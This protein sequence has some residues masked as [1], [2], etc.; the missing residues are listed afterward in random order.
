M[1][2]E[3]F[4]P[5]LSSADHDVNVR[6]NKRHTAAASPSSA[7][8]V[9]V[10]ITKRE[11]DFLQQ[12]P[13]TA[14][15]ATQD[16]AVKPERDQVQPALQLHPS[17]VPVSRSPGTAAQ[18]IH[19]VG[20]IGSSH[21]GDQDSTARAPMQTTPRAAMAAAAGDIKAVVLLLGSSNEQQQKD[22]ARQLA[23]MTLHG[24]GSHR[25]TIAAEA[26]VLVIAAAGV[27]VILRTPHRGSR[28]FQQ[29]QQPLHGMLYLVITLNLLCATAWLGCISPIS[30][31]WQ[32]ALGRTGK[33]WS[34]LT[35]R[36]RCMRLLCNA[37]HQRVAPENMA[38]TTT[39]LAALPRLHTDIVSCHS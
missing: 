24:T 37:V 39:L 2:E 31:T 26:G 21:G 19:A 9:Q 14:A 23:D 5:Y 29:Q 30:A 33:T 15:P 27:L 13:T 10:L 12:L 6:P 36:I 18:H 7:P 28:R 16:V 20:L 8:A 3:N 17:A 38:A 11:G 4:T 1:K 22:G 32:H 25:A 34:Q 35:S